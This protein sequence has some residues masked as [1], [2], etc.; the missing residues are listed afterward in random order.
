MNI[1]PLI[2]L[3]LLVA[4][5]SLLVGLGTYYVVKTQAEADKTALNDSITALNKKVAD[6]EATDGDTE[7]VETATETTTPST[8]TTAP[9]TTTATDETADWKTYSNTS[10]KY[11]FKYPTDW[12]VRKVSTGTDTSYLLSWQGANPVSHKEDHIVLVAVSPKTVSE[13]VKNRVAQQVGI[14]ADKVAEESVKF[15]TYNATALKITK[16]VSGVTYTTYFIS[17]NGKTF[18][19]DGSSDS[20]DT[21]YKTAQQIVDNFKFTD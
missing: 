16:T 14:A 12:E 19:I 18:I 8:T 17:R 15:N 1:H 6:L 10:Y 3:V 11:S 4:I 7:A 13:E 21:Y 20:K 2:K 5:P 9:S